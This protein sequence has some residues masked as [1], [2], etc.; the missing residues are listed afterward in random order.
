MQA[1][2]KD[3]S[4]RGRRTGLVLLLLL[5]WAAPALAQRPNLSGNWMLNGGKTTF[6]MWELT[7]AGRG[8]FEA[9]DFKTDDPALKYIGASW[10]RVWLN[11]NVL[12]Q[13]N[14]HSRFRLDVKQEDGSVVEWLVEMG[15]I[16]TM[17]R[18]GFQTERFA[19]GDP[20]TIVGS[21]GRR[22]RVVLLRAVV[23]QD[24]TKL[25]P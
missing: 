22:D 25:S 21:P 24:G 1:D 12:V 16:N 11:P 6:G 14:P 7:D 19:V 2:A 20:V 23:L 10:T 4:A 5:A 13:I 9:Y 3:S 8:R 15:A 18:A 17:Q